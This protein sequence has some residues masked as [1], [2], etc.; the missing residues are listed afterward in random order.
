MSEFSCLNAKDTEKVL[1]EFWLLFPPEQNLKLGIGFNLIL[2]LV[3][4][5]KMNDFLRPIQ[6]AF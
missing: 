2:L 5:L 6:N 3:F 4:L 1:L